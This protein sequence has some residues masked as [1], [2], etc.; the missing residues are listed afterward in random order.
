VVEG[1]LKAS[2][3]FSNGKTLIYS[4][5]PAGSWIGEGSVHKREVRHYDIVAIQP[6][7]LRG[8]SS[9]HSCSTVSSAGSVASLNG[10][11]TAFGG[12]GTS[13]TN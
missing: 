2:S 5:I 4:G 9:I 10:S 8:A 11:L 12:G 3:G 1:L 13:R 6:V 7:S